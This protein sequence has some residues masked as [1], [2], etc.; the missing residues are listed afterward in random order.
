MVK[1]NLNIFFFVKKMLI[2]ANQNAKQKKNLVSDI[3]K[4]IKDLKQYLK[5][6]KDS[7]LEYNCLSTNF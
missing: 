7:K 3:K 2:Q 1:T 6:N 4:T 5:K